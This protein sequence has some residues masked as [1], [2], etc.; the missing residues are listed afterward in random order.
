MSDKN[1]LLI[2]LRADIGGGPRHV[3][4]IF[5]N[6]KNN[7]NLF[8]ASPI[9]E[10]YGIKWHNE[11][12]STNKFLELPHRKLSLIYLMRLK[13]FSRKNKIK[14][15]HAHGR[16]A[17]IY[18]RLLKIFKPKI[19]V[20]YTLHGFHISSFKSFKKIIALLIERF[21]SR[22]TDIFINIS[23]NERASAVSHKI[24]DEKKS[25]IIYNGIADKFD[26][27]VDM[28]L[29]RQ[30][31]NLP[32]NKFIVCYLTR[33][34]KLKNVATFIQI[35]KLLENEKDIYFVLAGN[36]DEMN[37]VK[38]SIQESNLKNILLTGFVNNPIE[39]LTSS[40]IY[41]STAEVEG[42]PYSI[43]EAMMCGKPVIASNVRGNNELVIDEL[44][45]FLFEL[46]NLSQAVDKILKLKNDK[47][48]YDEFSVNGRK[49]YFDFFTE[50]VMIEKLKKV[51]ESFLR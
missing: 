40:D 35:A 1:I 47:K 50:D 44:N 16:G 7:F 11:L 10:P 41:L 26:S 9:E 28:K 38:D 17:G 46:N 2:T 37:K 24:L 51:Y 27:S 3:D 19:K 39:Y 15:V 30:N 4:S 29:L 18:G 33:F 23:E 21:L 6:L 32:E 49:R 43:I 48:L 13:S 42:L 8:V 31:L 22:F 5:N 36:G 14:V 45:G 34:D 12:K 25:C 20:I